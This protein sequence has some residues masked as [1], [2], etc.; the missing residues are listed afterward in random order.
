MIILYHFDE[1]NGIPS[2]TLFAEKGFENVY[3][4]SG[5]IEKFLQNFP[6]GV[7]GTKVP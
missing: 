2:A 7:T 6:E 3:L 5:G 4:V 1:K